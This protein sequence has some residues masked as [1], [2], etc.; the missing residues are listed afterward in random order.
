MEEKNIEFIDLARENAIRE[1][2][3]QILF[4]DSDVNVF[5]YN[6]GGK[7]AIYGQ[8]ERP[9]I[10][11]KNNS[12][13]KDREVANMNCLSAKV[14]GADSYRRYATI[15]SGFIE[16]V[17]FTSDTTDY[18]QSAMN[19]PMKLRLDGE[20]DW[21]RIL[22]LTIKHD[23]EIIDELLAKGKIFAAALL[24]EDSKA[25][26]VWTDKTPPPPEDSECFF[27]K[28]ALKIFGDR[29]WRIPNP[30]R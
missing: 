28:I 4:G 12:L 27:R 5:H 23:N 1:I 19:F 11:L 13:L 24:L 17:S 29:G 7:S 9:V 15:Y 20:I 21:N 3:E 16:V 18:F 14:L 22:D 6:H 2:V 26:R 10:D 8:D 30:L 25:R